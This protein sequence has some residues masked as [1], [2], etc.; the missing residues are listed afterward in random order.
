MQRRI[1]LGKVPKNETDWISPLQ[2]WTASETGRLLLCCSVVLSDGRDASC[3]LNSDV[4]PE[5]TYRGL[6]PADSTSHAAS[7]AIGKVW[8]SASSWAF[9]NDGNKRTTRKKY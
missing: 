4:P 2:S 1:N 5:S 7:T 9:D 8:I 6:R 3:S